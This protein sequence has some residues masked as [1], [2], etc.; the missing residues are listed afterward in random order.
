MASGNTS[1]DS[2]DEAGPE[3]GLQQF[4]GVFASKGWLGR[5]VRL[6]FRE[7]TYSVSCSSSG[8]MAYRVNDSQGTSHGFPG[9]PVCIVDREMEV[10]H[11]GTSPLTSDEPSAADWLR[12]ITNG[13]FQVT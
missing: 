9:W 6:R 5:S 10:G 12:C 11:S 2:A 13:E 7:R 3:A 8:F 4:I 1:F